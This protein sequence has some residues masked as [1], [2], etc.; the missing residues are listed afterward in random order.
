MPGPDRRTAAKPVHRK[1]S[2]WRFQ[3]IVGLMAVAAV[4]AFLAYRFQTKSYITAQPL[5]A[6][7]QRYERLV[8]GRGNMLA[9]GRIDGGVLKIRREETG[10]ASA[11]GVEIPAAQIIGGE[12]NWAISETMDLVAWVSPGSVWFRT[13]E[14]ASTLREVRLSASGAPLAVTVL[15]DGLVAVVFADGTVA[16]WNP[17]TEEAL[18][19]HKLD[20]GAL[21]QAV[22]AGDYVAASSQERVTLYRYR[23]GR[24]INSESVF[25][26]PP[27][28]R[29]T[30]PAPGSLATVSSGFL[31]YGGESRNTPGS[32]HSVVSYQGTP[33]VTGSFED[34][35]TVNS[36]KLAEEDYSVA[37][38]EP[39]SVLAAGSSRIAISSGKGT[40]L[41]T[42]GKEER[43]TA[44][45]RV[46]ALL[47]LLSAISSLLVAILP[48][49]L[50]QFLKLFA[51]LMGGKG[52]GAS[53]QLPPLFL[54]RP[55][56]A[57][58]ESLAASRGV[59]W[60]GA[61][62]SAQAGLTL[63]TAFVTELV[64][65][66]VVESW[67]G[68]ADADR[69]Q[70]LIEEGRVEEAMDR[71]TELSPQRVNPE[72]IRSMIP[73]Y[74]VLSRCHEQLA[75]IPFAAG[76]TTNYDDLLE[77]MKARWNTLALTPGSEDV[78]LAAGL[79]SLM[80]LYGNV[81]SPATIR[82]T[83]GKLAADFPAP[84][85]RLLNNI[86]SLNTVFFVGTSLEALL[87]DLDALGLYDIR[88][89]QHYVVTGS[90][91][92]QWKKYADELKGRYSIEPIVCNEETIATELPKFVEELT[93]NVQDLIKPDQSRDREGAD[94]PQTTLS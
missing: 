2:L 3:L 64:N 63:R 81:A 26:P 43:L 12:S 17:R 42:I 71:L 45:G 78:P 54:V 82:M 40:E 33:I 15:Y 85:K 77:K 80:K 92:P 22:A 53:G 28:F 19:T 91:N 32:V 79:P 29:V 75:T 38:A 69:L 88:G 72:T 31:R 90:A 48:M 37:K 27:P 87:A 46:A 70:A 61:G 20:L 73:R 6:F 86:G 5:R 9:G 1:Q 18:P 4:L 13:M 74:T 84:A 51:K 30:I 7:P 11:A 8:F 23:D 56:V 60:A 83:R 55:P 34:V 24:W 57:L 58:I 76:I 21:T 39:D 89:G 59:L 93:K 35:W 94:T 41:F 36:S 52:G 14:D 10:G 44:T 25:T 47:S 65:A 67:I 68:S 49:L 66:G 50:K 16:R 62:L